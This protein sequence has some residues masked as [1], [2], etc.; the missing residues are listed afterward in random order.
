MG[1]EVCWCGGEL[2][3]ASCELRAPAA[4]C[5][6]SR[7]QD[8]EQEVQEKS[9]SS[10]TDV[11]ILTVASETRRRRFF[12]AA[13]SRVFHQQELLPGIPAPPHPAPR[14]HPP[15]NGGQIRAGGHLQSEAAAAAARENI[16]DLTGLDGGG[17]EDDGMRWLD[18]IA[19]PHTD[20]S[21]P[22]GQIISK[23]A[24]DKGD[25]CPKKS[26]GVNQTVVFRAA[27]VRRSDGGMGEKT[28]DGQN[29][30]KEV[31]ATSPLLGGWA[32][33]EGSKR[34]G[35]ADAEACSS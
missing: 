29:E 8:R 10:F 1:C 14:S 27:A 4:C 9:R 32:A 34:G 18:P 20:E 26:R 33:G 6:R 2:R 17:T 16:K 21:P 25:E 24:T 11:M 22:R 12:C 19:L 3:A 28:H 7:Q 31:G 15:P 5:T 13:F 30:Q 35:G 23:G